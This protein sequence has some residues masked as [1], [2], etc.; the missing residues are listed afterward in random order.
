MISGNW[1]ACQHI[2]LSSSSEEK[3]NM[4][5]NEHNNNN[6]DERQ[7]SYMYYGWIIQSLQII[8]LIWQITQRTSGAK[9]E[10]EQM[11]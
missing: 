5:V 4:S 10:E 3:V 6:D 2:E 11:I 1:E 8:Y 9:L 7:D